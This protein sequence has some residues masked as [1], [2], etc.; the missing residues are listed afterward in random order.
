MGTK[1]R[2]KTCHRTIIRRLSLKLPPRKTKTPPKWLNKFIF[3][4]VDATIDCFGPIY[5]NNK[6]K[7]DFPSK[8]IKLPLLIHDDSLGEIPV[9]ISQLKKSNPNAFI[10]IYAGRLH[11]SKI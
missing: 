5:W 11:P 3:S 1:H 10:L 6:N 8:Y 9:E 7:S 4:K 2:E